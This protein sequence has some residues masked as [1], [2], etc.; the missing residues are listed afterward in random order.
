MQYYAPAITAEQL[1]EQD[2][3]KRNFDE[4]EQRNARFVERMTNNEEQR[5]RAFDL[6]AR[7]AKTLTM[8]GTHWERVYYLSERLHDIA[9]ELR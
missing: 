3:R 6:V 7:L 5:D 4:K 1:Y 9:D 8:P 2:T